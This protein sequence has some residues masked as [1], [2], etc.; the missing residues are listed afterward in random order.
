MD[1]SNHGFESS[2]QWLEEQELTPLQL[3]G[4]ATWLIQ[5]VE[6]IHNSTLA[7]LQ[8]DPEAAHSLLA[9]WAIDA[10]RLMHARYM[11][12]RVDLFKPPAGA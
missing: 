1:L 4:L 3:R 7:A 6:K 5:R 8:A 10:D 11:L 2:V 12:E 9:L